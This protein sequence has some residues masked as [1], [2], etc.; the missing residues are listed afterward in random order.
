M[1]SAAISSYPCD[2][3]CH[4][5]F[6]AVGCSSMTGELWQGFF[7]LFWLRFVFTNVSL[8]SVLLM[9]GKKNVSDTISFESG[10]SSVSFCSGT[11]FLCCGSDDCQ[12]YVVNRDSKKV[13]L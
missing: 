4:D 11:P 9:D 3:S 12:V 1:F 8:G 7:L 10:I 2:L 5:G 13:T 6:T